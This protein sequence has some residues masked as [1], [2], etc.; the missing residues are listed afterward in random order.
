M[1]ELRSSSAYAACNVPFGCVP[2][3][4]THC[5]PLDSALRTAKPSDE[6]IA[7]KSGLKRFFANSAPTYIFSPPELSLFTVSTGMN[8]PVILPTQ[9][10]ISSAAKRSPGCARSGTT[11]SIGVMA[12]KH[13]Q[14]SDIISS[15]FLC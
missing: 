13:M 7:L 3:T 11:I 5:A 8:L 4:N 9:F 1:S 14:N 10:W 2:N 6:P 12:A 15:A